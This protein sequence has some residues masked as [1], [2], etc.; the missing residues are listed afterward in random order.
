VAPAE[1]LLRKA[2][3]L[4]MP[5]PRK[6][7]AP[8]LVMVWPLRSSAAPLLTLMAPVPAPVA[9]PICKVPALMLVPPV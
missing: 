5:V 8:V 6:V 3:V 4:L 9:A 1:L 2:P 7:N